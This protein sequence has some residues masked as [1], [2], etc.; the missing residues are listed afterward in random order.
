VRLALA[1]ATLAGTG[2]TLLLGTLRWATRPRLVERLRPYVAGVAPTAGDGHRSAA[3]PGD[4]GS[5]HDLVTSFARQLGDVVGR[6]GGS[7]DPL[8]TRLVRLHLPPDVTAFRTRQLAAAGLGLV[9]GLLAVVALRPPAAVVALVLLAGPALGFLVPEQRL[10]TATARWRARVELELP[11]VAEQL[12]MLLGAGFSLGAALARLGERGSGVV[13][14][15]LRRVSA[16]VRHGLTE[17]AALRE[18]ADLAGVVAVDRLVQVL[19]LE[20]EA[21]DLGRMVGEEARAMRAE[22]HRRLLEQVERR[23]QQVWIPVTVAALLPGVLFLA[24]PFLEAVRLFGA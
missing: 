19:V 22:A 2:A 5:W 14:A 24:V 21:S 4:A 10:G 23:G 20:R 1:V 6:L 13:A 9:A 7:G 12:A 17:A 11:V 18:W 8:A 16:R 15:D 3:R